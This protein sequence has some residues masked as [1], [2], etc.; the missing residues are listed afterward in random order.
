MQVSV[1][2]LLNDPR[3]RESTT[4]DKMAVSG[5]AGSP[6]THTPLLS[7]WRRGCRCD[8]EPLRRTP[9]KTCAA[10]SPVDRRS[11]VPEI[12]SR[13]VGETAGC[14]GPV[15]GCQWCVPFYG[16][17]CGRVVTKCGVPSASETV[18][19]RST[20]FIKQYEHTINSMQHKNMHTSS[21]AACHAHSHPVSRHSPLSANR[22][23]KRE[24]TPKNDGTSVENSS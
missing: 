4:T 9:Q 13:I 15:S 10:V 18:G 5:A 1:S 14:L 16:V 8:G 2:D 21:A 24:L 22:P 6:P 3:C 20:Q 23:A 17:C 19:M 12:T 7:A 11:T